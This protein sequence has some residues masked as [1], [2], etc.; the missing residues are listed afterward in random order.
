MESI[1]PIERDME[2]AGWIDIK[3]INST[4]RIEEQFNLVEWESNN[5]K[6]YEA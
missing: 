4:I 1:N 2:I 6:G 5:P 3:N